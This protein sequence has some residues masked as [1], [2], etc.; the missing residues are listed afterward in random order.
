VYGIQG[1]RNPFIDH[2]EYVNYIWGSGLAEEPENHATN[3]SANTI[4]LNWSD[5]TGP[6]TPDAYLVRMSAVGF[7]DIATPANGTPVSDDFLN[8]NVPYGT[9][10][11]TFGGLTPGDT[12][13]FKIFG[14][15]GSGGSITYKTDGQVQQISMQAK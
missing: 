13:Y 11:V 4:T 3:F 8:K 6:V 1:N 9:G 2:P 10:T 14:Y 7:G 5:A 12:Y 15:T